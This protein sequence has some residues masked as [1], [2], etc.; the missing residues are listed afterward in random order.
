M[1]K[2]IFAAALTAAALSW[3]VGSVSAQSSGTA[4]EARAMLDNAVVALKANEA[5][6]LAA[7]NDKSNT[8]FRDR[9]LYVFCYDMTDGKFTAHA[10]PAMMGT[11]VRA[12]KA[13]DDPLGQ[14][15]SKRSTNHQEELSSR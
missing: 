5:T 9:D 3:S 2:R 6:A 10:N 8:K 11:D 12:L 14:K 15:S 4:A 7:F 1:K 13:K